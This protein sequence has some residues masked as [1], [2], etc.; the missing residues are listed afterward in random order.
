MLASVEKSRRQKLWCDVDS[1]WVTAERIN[2]LLNFK[3]NATKCWCNFNQRAS[4]KH[5]DVM[6]SVWVKCLLV[7]F[8]LFL[9]CILM[10]YIF[11]HQYFVFYFGYIINLL[12]HFCSLL[13]KDSQYFLLCVQLVCE[14][15]PA[16]VGPFQP[17]DPVVRV[18]LL[19]D[20][21]LRCVV[22]ED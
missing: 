19:L 6:T 5:E 12:Y 17:A 2:K 1:T 16:V 13:L 7:F 8:K 9:T 14:R 18:D 3:P 11:S 20:F 21:K 10:R 22:N 15:V 4:D